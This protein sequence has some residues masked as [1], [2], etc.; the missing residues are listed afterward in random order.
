MINQLNK[1]STPPTFAKAYLVFSFQ[2]I[3]PMSR[4]HA[5]S[6]I[7]FKKTSSRF[8]FSRR[9]SSICTPALT[10]RATS[11]PIFRLP[12]ASRSP[13]VNFAAPPAVPRRN[14]RSWLNTDSLKTTPVDFPNAERRLAGAVPP[15][16][17]CA[18]AAP[19]G[20]RPPECTIFSASERLWVVKKNSHSVL[21]GQVGQVLPAAPAR[22]YRVETCGGFRLKRRFLGRCSR[23]RATASF[24]VFMPRL[25]LP[26]SFCASFP[27]NPGPS[28]N[29]WM[30]AFTLARRQF[31]D[32][33][34][35]NSR[36]SSALMRSYNPVCFQ[37]CA[38]LLAHCLSLF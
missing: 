34:H 38:A 20:S 11:G 12:G 8:A 9:T 36:L 31:P 27:I 16:Y 21:R 23:A 28:N 35:K 32:S 24:F 5:S 25:Q 14:R 4:H 1:V 6:S 18:R 15:A 7:I 19:G 30:R 22:G 29:S 37:Q 26:T 3:V 33:S 13:S 10:S 17:P 2:M